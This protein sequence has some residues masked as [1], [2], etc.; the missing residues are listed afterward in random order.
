M[1]DIFSKIEAFGTKIKKPNSS[2]EKQAIEQGAKE[3]GIDPVDYATAISYETGGTFHPWQK[4]PVTKWGQHRGTIQYGEPQRKKYGVYEGQ[5]FEEQ[6]TKSNVKYLKDAGVKPGMTFA[7]IYAA[8]NGGSVNKDLSTPDAGTDRTIAD[9]IRNAERDH[10]AAVIKRFGFA[11]SNGDGRPDFSEVRAILNDGKP[12][13]GASEEEAAPDFSDIRAMYGK[14]KVQTPSIQDTSRPSVETPATPTNQT[15]A[16]VQAPQATAQVDP[17]KRYEG[18]A[19]VDIAEEDV[20]TL[21]RP[22]TMAPR[23][24][25]DAKESSILGTYTTD[26]TK[27]DEER[28]RTAATSVLSTYGVTPQE[29][30]QWI[31]GEKAAGRPLL[32]G[33]TRNPELTIT[34]G[35]LDQI[36]GA[37][38]AQSELDRER[39]ET[40]LEEVPPESLLTKDLLTQMFGEEEVQIGAGISLAGASMSRYLAGLQRMMSPSVIAGREDAPGS[41]DLEIRAYQSGKDS[42]EWLKRMAEAPEKNAQDLNDGLYAEVFQMVGRTPGD[43]GRVL[44][45]SA[46]LPGGIVTASSLDLAAQSAG[47]DESF[48][49]VKRQAV[50][51]ALLGGLAK[52]LM[53]VTKTLASTNLGSNRAL[54]FAG[55]VGYTAGG[56]YLTSKLFGADDK[57]ALKETLF[58]TVLGLGDAAAVALRGRTVRVRNLKGDDVT[59]R[60]DID[61]NA[62]SVKLK[63]TENADLEILDSNQ[64]ITT[65]VKTKPEGMDDAAYEKQKEKANEYL[66]NAGAVDV[67]IIALQ[68]KAR[69]DNGVLKVDGYGNMLLGRANSL[70]LGQHIDMFGAYYRPA[71]LSGMIDGL[72]QMWNDYSDRGKVA[73]AKNVRDFANQ[74]MQARDKVTGDLVVATDLAGI[75]PDLEAA[76][77]QE[78]LTHRNSYRSGLRKLL[79]TV[80]VESPELLQIAK[81]LEEGGY[82]KVPQ[83][84]L[85]DEAMAKVFRDDAERHLDL[86]KKET[87]AGRKAVYNELVNLAIDPTKFSAGLKDV[88]KKGA[89]FDRYAQMRERAKAP[90]PV[91]VNPDA[92]KR[93][94]VE[95]DGTIWRSGQTVE[96]TPENVAAVVAA[97]EHG[98]QETNELIQKVKVAPENPHKDIGGLDSGVLNQIFGSDHWYGGK[99]R[100]EIIRFLEGRNR[101][102]QQYI[103][104]IQEAGQNW[105]DVNGAP[106]TIEQGDFVTVKSDL[107]H[108]DNPYIV[109]EIQGDQ[110]VLID[111]MALDQGNTV[112]V[113]LS[114]LDIHTKLNEPAGKEGV[115]SEVDIFAEEGR[116]QMAGGG[117]ATARRFSTETPQMQEKIERLLKEGKNVQYLG[118]K[119]VIVND[120]R[121]EYYARLDGEGKAVRDANDDIVDRPVQVA[122][123]RAV[124]GSESGDYTN[125]D[126]FTAEPTSLWDAEVFP[127][128]PTKTS[129][130][131]VMDEI[132]GDVFYVPEQVAAQALKNS[133]EMLSLSQYLEDHETLGRYYL[134]QYLPSWRAVSPKKQTVDNT[135]TIARV[136]HPTLQTVFKDNKVFNRADQEAILDVLDK[137]FPA[138]AIWN[139]RR[140]KDAPTAA[141][142]PDPAVE[143]RFVKAKGLPEEGKLK[144]TYDALVRTYQ[145]FRR[146]FH[147]LDPNKN[148][149][150][151]RVAD[152]FRRLTAVPH[153]A[154]VKAQDTVAA[155]TK[156]LGPNNFKTFERI[157]QLRDI[158]R[159]A[160]R[161]IQ[162]DLGLADL[163]QVND[164]LA[165]F[166]K[167]AA[168]HPEI[169]EALARRE[170]MI[171]DVTRQMVILDL[172][173]QSAMDD[174][175]YYHRQVLSAI[176]NTY[177]SVGSQDVRL[178]R[179]GFQKTR[180]GEKGDYNTNYLESEAEWL[181]QA[182]AQLAKYD[183]QQE[184]EAAANIAPMLKRDAKLRGIKDWTSLIDKKTHTLWQPKEGNYFFRVN[185]IPEEVLTDLMRGSLKLADLPK[186]LGEALGMGRR[187]PEWVVPKEVAKLLDRFKPEVEDIAVRQVFATVNG[188]IKQWMLLNPKNFVGYNLRNTVSDLDVVMARYP[189]ALKE[190]WGA[191]N[192]LRNYTKNPGG[193]EAKIVH[194]AIADGVIDSGQTFAEIPDI[195]KIKAFKHITD[196][197]WNPLAKAWD[198]AKSTT[199]FRENLLR[200][201][202]YEHLKKKVA[203]G[204]P[205]YG[206]SVKGQVDAITNPRLKAA[207]VAREFMGD[208]GGISETGRVIRKHLMPF[209]SW[210][211]INAPRY[212]RMMKNMRHEG[213][214]FKVGPALVGKGLKVAYN[215][216]KYAA[217]LI[218]TTGMIVLWN[219]YGPYA[220]L[221]EK[222]KKTDVGRQPH[223]IV[224]VREDGTPMIIRGETALTDA[225]SWLAAGDLDADI[226]EIQA[227]KATA[228]D[229]VAEAGKAL[230]FDRPINAVGPQYKIP[231]E[232]ALGSSAY[233]SIFEKGAS[234]D[235]RRRPIKDNWEYVARAAAVDGIYKYAMGRPAP[236]SSGV[237]EKLTD[238]FLTSRIDA[239]EAVYWNARTNVSSYAEKIGKPS[240]AAEATKKSNALFYYR[241]ALKWGDE[242]AARRY[243]DEYTLLSKAEGHDDEEVKKGLEKSMQKAH[244]LG[245]LDSEKWGEYIRSLNQED[246]NQLVLALGF[247]K[248]AYDQKEA[249]G[250]EAGASVQDLYKMVFPKPVRLIAENNTTIPMAVDIFENAGLDEAELKRVKNAIQLRA[251]QKIK[252]KSLTHED[253]AALTRIGIKLVADADINMLQYA[254]EQKKQAQELKKA[255]KFQY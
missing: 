98:I 197:D 131:P 26:P 158:Q 29:V 33:D 124:D 168:A 184:I 1:D 47:R 146:E 74:V 207:K 170:K 53:P 234:F 100:E 20:P 57:T 72:E 176:E 246:R 179:K 115:T 17:A 99:S 203:Q 248:N 30:T 136:A 177:G 152:A 220:E 37:G 155:I 154:K 132:S 107:Q 193:P 182:H 64:P 85:L 90:K 190:V 125:L 237:G 123:W 231:A 41:E 164:S 133:G 44:L 102:N 39:A 119:P 22:R 82:S 128:S 129:T 173:P 2:T 148:P 174:P 49:E 229:K 215:A 195:N 224:G 198:M 206:G 43:L 159:E 45:S 70:G 221:E 19:G 94:N 130:V 212:I 54:G 73:E 226:A 104:D 48:D 204:I 27:S 163:Q 161:G 40:Q 249:I 200:L 121:N 156:D 142:D 105:K 210:M 42:F 95:A 117:L 110:A 150:N 196:G 172:L 15:A 18:D 235:L 199:N 183:I 244:P 9:N 186:E 51:G 81:S 211:E 23:Q 227:G 109:H 219:N 78:E 127:T 250:D 135:L 58:N 38:T 28:L 254:G 108:G 3:L 103:A 101:T 145:S 241:Q 6:V 240:Q 162:P 134:E 251:I 88:S 137:D 144:K 35:M 120:P 225:M 141:V 65:K 7:Q 32:V 166:E 89:A 247:Y 76:T 169:A 214:D 97:S 87:R 62:T 69:I 116:D 149:E 66:E 67:D 218:A 93:K 143:E 61:G 171:G 178:H 83:D 118:K 91:K 201:A 191:Y 243:L 84:S 12:A 187:K 21:E 11:D 255:A 223:I 126:S 111:A 153:W 31:E 92:V 140:P 181:S 75:A 245:G 189:G 34:A 113:P 194:D 114:E 213:E 16:P 80:G 228:I 106:E 160:E 71:Q 79:Q 188:G 46:V 50:K 24:E 68:G 233:P 253:Q 238:S 10:R 242:N 217:G 232:L 175:R 239:D 165:H 157:V 96:P 63:P 112:T 60:F 230:F 4:G 236:K 209:Y 59:V 25:A 147:E 122:S 139:S 13:A 55:G 202:V 8:I 138:L 14:D 252:N 86:S 77:I 222:L 36:K 208:Y 205:V 216:P 52:T 180:M 185:T 192:L 56:T 5:S 151:A 167:E